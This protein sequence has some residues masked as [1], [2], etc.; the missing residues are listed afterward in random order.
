[1]TLLSNFAFSVN[2]PSISAV[3]NEKINYVI[4]G[5]VDNIKPKA[6][7]ANAA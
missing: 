3:K 7:P 6:A 1:M 4:N 2:G 5:S